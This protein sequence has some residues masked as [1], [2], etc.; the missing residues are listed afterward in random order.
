MKKEIFKK[1]LAHEFDINNRWNHIWADKAERPNRLPFFSSWAIYGKNELKNMEIIEDNIIKSLNNNIVFVGLNFAKPLPDSWGVWQNIYENFNVKWLLGG[2]N[3]DVEKYRGA[4]ITDIIKN[5]IGSVAKKVMSELK[6]KNINDNIGWFFDEIDLLESDSIEMYLFGADVEYLFKKYV[7]KHDRFSEFQRKVKKCQRIDHYGGANLNFR[8]NAPTQLGLAQNDTVKIY[9]PLWEDGISVPV[10]EGIIRNIKI[11]KKQK[12][13]FM[14]Q[15]FIDILKQL[16]KEQGNAALTDIRKCKALLADYTRN[17][18]KK[19]SAWIMQA[20]EAGI[21]KAI[22]GADDLA[23]CKKAKIR[24]L[25]EEKGLNSVVATDIVDTLAL[26]MRGNTT[27]T[28]IKG[29]SINPPTGECSS[30]N[31]IDDLFVKILSEYTDKGVKFLHLDARNICWFTKSLDDGLFPR[32]EDNTGRFK[33]RKYCYGYDKNTRFVHLVLWPF[34]QDEKTIKIMNDLK[35]F[36]NPN[37][38]YISREEINRKILTYE[39]LRAKNYKNKEE[40]IREAINYSLNTGEV[41]VKKFGMYSHPSL[42]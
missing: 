34:N 1:L 22:D 35:N 2:E 24:E 21:A 31:N 20:V 13:I 12:E 11:P 4:Y 10:V 23:A 5:I 36:W 42:K 14:E 26:V 27:K 29:S 40:E 17:D 37:K 9:P 38:P 8:T 41:I 7:V 39:E 16:V 28:P 30:T 32:G 25:E 15:G 3:F 33:G 18:Y 6:I 19:E